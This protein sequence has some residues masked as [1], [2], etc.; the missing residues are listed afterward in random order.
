[1][2]RFFLLFM[3]HISLFSATVETFNWPNGETY[4]TFLEKHNLPT[5]T[6]FYNIDKDDQKQAEEILTG[7]HYQI[8]KNE[9]TGEIEQVLIPL[10]DEL[11]I[12]LYEDNGY[13]FEIIPIISKTKT[14][15]FTLKIQNSPYYD[16]YKATSSY[17]I[18][19]IFISAFK[20]SL[21]FKTDIRKGDTLVMIYQQKYRLGQPFSM[22][23]LE[24][25]MIE[26]RKKKHFIYLNSDDRYYDEKG[27]QVEEFLLALPV[28][29]ARISSY[30]TKRR[31]H[32][33]LH[34]WKAHLGID[35]AAR[36]GT[37]IHAA[38]S[39][40]VI[41]KRY[42]NS[43]GNITIIKHK[44]GYSTRYAHQKAF[45]RGLYVGKHVKRGQIIGYVGTTGRSTGPHLHFELRKYGRAINPLRVVQVATKK[46]RGKKRRAFLKLKKKYDKA[47]FAELEKAS[48][49]KKCGKNDSVCYLNME[50]IND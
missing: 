25:A 43:Y 33:I 47:I 1:M 13:K 36:R 28:R 2:I 6:L 10:N 3:L 31:W 42:S 34:K 15:A 21:N 5:K 37:P 20:K 41:S 46:L 14:E 26:M 38:A 17:K 29:G 50:N 4:L 16:I 44:D 11:Q 23:K 32:P 45:K 19:K 24:T 27:T 40:I 35:Y 9:K 7:V 30:F 8:L 22:P 48:K 12:H 18:A 49:Y 39:G